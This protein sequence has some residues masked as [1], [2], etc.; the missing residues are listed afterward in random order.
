MGE[1]YK[2]FYSGKEYDFA[3]FIESPETVE[4]YKH[5]STIPLIDVVSIYKIFVNRQGGS[6]GVLDEASKFELQNE[7]DTAD[8]DEIIKK[9]IRDGSI[10]NKAEIHRG[11]NSHND[12][13]GAGATGN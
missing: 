1:P 2:V 7:F 11:H 5:D 8:K 4:R 10:R 12:S 9:I 6:E 13:Y 3:V